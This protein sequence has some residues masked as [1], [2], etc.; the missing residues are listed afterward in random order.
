MKVAA[1][2]LNVHSAD[3]SQ[4]HQITRDKSATQPVTKEFSISQLNGSSDVILMSS[5]V[6][7]GWD[8][9]LNMIVRQTR[10]IFS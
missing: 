9:R 10:C 5:D 6:I 4:E 8:W 7:S 1:Y 3:F 2:Y